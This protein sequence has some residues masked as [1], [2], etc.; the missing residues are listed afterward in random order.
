MTQEV[1][2]IYDG[3]VLRLCNPVKLKKNNHYRVLIEIE[4][5]EV[6]GNAWDVLKSMTGTI[7]GPEDWSEE[8]D[9]YLYNTPKKYE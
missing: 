7:E 4:E 5:E 6:S 3:E 8:L 1:E 9:H 2:V